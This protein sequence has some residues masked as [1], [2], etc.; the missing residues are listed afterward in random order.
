[1]TI[2]EVVAAGS[3]KI[4][5][6]YILQLVRENPG[7]TIDREVL[8]ALVPLVR[9]RQVVCRLERGVSRYYTPEYVEKY[10]L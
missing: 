9:S 7:T 6:E 3:T 2:E 4:E 8:S 5:Q 1:M 10:N